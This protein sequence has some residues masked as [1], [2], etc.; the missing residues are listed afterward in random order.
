[1]L[2][3]RLIPPAKR[4]GDKGTVNMREVVVSVSHWVPTDAMRD[5]ARLVVPVR[6]G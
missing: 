5:A 4:G 3:E 1:M 6:S 2:V